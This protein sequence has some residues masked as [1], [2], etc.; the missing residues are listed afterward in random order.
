MQCAASAVTQS[1]W[2]GTK[3]S[4]K[5]GLTQ[6]AGPLERR[7]ILRLHEGGQPGERHV[8]HVA[9]Q[10]QIEHGRPARDF[11]QPAAAILKAEHHVA[12]VQFRQANAVAALPQRRTVTA[13]QVGTAHR[14]RQPI[15]HEVGFQLH[16]L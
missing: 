6:K 10:Q 9:I 16:A 12:I 11:F 5:R 13:L 4:P 15:D 14:E 1:G 2:P 3:A 7:A 8:H